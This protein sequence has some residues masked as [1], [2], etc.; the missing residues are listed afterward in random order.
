MKNQDQMSI[1]QDILL[2]PF[3]S[4]GEHGIAADQ[5]NPAIRLY[6]RRFYKDQTPLEYLAEFLLVFASPK[7]ATKQGD[8]SLKLDPN[9]GASV[10]WPEDRVALKLFTFFPS[11][12]LE[13]RHP[14]HQMEYLQA[15]EEIKAHISGSSVEKDEAVRLLQSLFSGFVGVAKTRTWVT[16][17]FLPASVSLLAREVTWNHPDAIKKSKKIEV[18]D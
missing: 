7:G 14:V 2:A 6:G 16:Y 10:Y 8:F 1:D 12:K 4:T 17:T 18:T 11:S 13:T 3:P 9:D 5:N 15:L